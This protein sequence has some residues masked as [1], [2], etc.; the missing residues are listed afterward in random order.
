MHTAKHTTH[1]NNMQGFTLI[2]WLV[3]MSIIAILA[4]IGLPNFSASIE[5]YRAG[6]VAGELARSLMTARTQALAT[7][8]RVVV[9]P[10][11]NNDWANGWRIFIDLNNN[12][13]LD[14]GDQ[15]I[16]EINSNPSA[17]IA[18]SALLSEGGQ[19]FVS[20]TGLGFPRALDGTS[21]ADGTLTITLGTTQRIVCLN[22]QGR[23]NV[24]D[25]GTC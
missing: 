2:E 10:M 19:S 7:G 24:I 18:P 3:V 9:S 23:V 1:C 5:R 25:Q 14:A 21:F 22:A 12:G 15:T 11:A 8:H 20:F 16:Q 17:G 4:V 6:S 13:S